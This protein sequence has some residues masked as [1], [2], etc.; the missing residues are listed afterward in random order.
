MIVI[1][2][3]DSKD[4]IKRI[5]DNH[6]GNGT[7]VEAS[8]LRE[9]VA[10]RKGYQISKTKRA[11]GSIKKRLDLPTPQ[12]GEQEISTYLKSGSWRLVICNSAAEAKNFQW[13][14]I[15]QFEP[16]LNIE[17]KP[18]HKQFRNRYE[19][20]LKNLLASPARTLNQLD[21]VHSGP[22]VYVLYHEVKP[23]DFFAGDVIDSD[24]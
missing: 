14:A 5:Q 15:E 21:A 18:W 6:C 12:I 16:L 13:Y 3:G 19:N 8:A 4:V 7:N 10:E 22:G 9:R 11:S 2:V 23:E 20:L 17:R 24:C 1:Y